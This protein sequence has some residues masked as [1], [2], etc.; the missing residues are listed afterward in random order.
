MITTV[1]SVFAVLSYVSI[2]EDKSILFSYVLFLSASHYISVLC[3]SPGAPLDLDNATIRGLCTVCHRIRGSRTKHCYICNKCYNKRDHHC[4]LIGRC[5]AEDNIK[6][7]F[8]CML[9]LGIFL[10]NWLITKQLKVL[11][12][13][14]VLGIVAFL[15]WMA[16][17][18]G[19]NKTTAEICKS[20]T[21]E[22][23]RED[24]VQLFRVLGSDPLRIFFPVLNYRSKVEY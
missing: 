10:V 11:I 23:R 5:V 2:F 8:L 18:I 1:L 12:A 6:D 16:L 19:T 22:I 24:I 4:I 15:S 13:I 20:W 17:C 14:P 9:F 7:L 21:G 3:K